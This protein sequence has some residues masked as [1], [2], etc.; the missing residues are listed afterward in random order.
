MSPLIVLLMIAFM[1]AVIVIGLMAY[2]DYRIKVK[3][4]EGHPRA[5][6]ME[7]QYADVLKELDAIK[8][9]FSDMKDWVDGK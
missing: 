5:K 1:I 2:L 6:Q 8:R 9:E 3:K 4:M 7:R